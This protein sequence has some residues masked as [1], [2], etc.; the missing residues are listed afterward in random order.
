MFAQIQAGFTSLAS[1]LAGENAHFA[2][3]YDEALSH[4]I[5]AGCDIILVPSMFEPCGLTQV[6]A[7]APSDAM[8][9]GH[10]PPWCTK[11]SM[12]LSDARAS[13]MLVPP[14][15]TALVRR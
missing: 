6:R 13:G 1:Q 3:S 4:L 10:C 2:F 8:L 5:Y 12:R 7:P 14:L 9:V 11:R 15:A